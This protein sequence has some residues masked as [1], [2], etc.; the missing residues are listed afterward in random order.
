MTLDAPI[1]DAQGRPHPAAFLLAGR[2][3]KFRAEDDCGDHVRRIA[4][5]IGKLPDLFAIC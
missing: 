4:L 5:Y 1:H 2:D 3:C